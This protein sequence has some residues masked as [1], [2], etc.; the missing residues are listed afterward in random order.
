MA[1]KPNSMRGKKVASVTKPKKRST[2]GK[3]IPS[4]VNTRYKVASR[5][6]KKK[7]TRRA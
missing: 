4:D 5:R 2:N 7:S 6:P 1:R 3:A